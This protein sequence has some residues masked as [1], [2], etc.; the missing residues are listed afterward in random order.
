MPNAT[1]S[2][3]LHHYDLKNLPGAWVKLRQLP[4]YQ[5]LE[6][7]DKA[8]KASMEQQINQG[9]RGQSQPQTAKMVLESLQT[10]ER[11]FM[12]KN[13]IADHN[14]T[15][16]SENPLD[17]NNPITLRSLRPDIGM[18]IERLIDELNSEGDEFQGDFPNAASNS[19][20]LPNPEQ[21]MSDNTDTTTS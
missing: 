9:K 21:P 12:F 2:Q 4:Y 16:A 20:E 7:R 1:V 8:T 18:E 17:F 14:L 11:D 5:M 15:D 10:W 13:C 3:E 6:R 19:S